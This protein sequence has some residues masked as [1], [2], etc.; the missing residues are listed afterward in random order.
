LVSY[1]VFLE[2]V[3]DL[4]VVGIIGGVILAG[5]ILLLI[6]VKNSN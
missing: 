2:N 1:D 5:A 3:G 6:W 4:M